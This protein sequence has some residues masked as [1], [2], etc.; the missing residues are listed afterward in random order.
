MHIFAPLL[1]IPLAWNYTYGLITSFTLL[2]LSTIA[3]MITVYSYEFPPTLAYMG[4]L[5]QAYNAE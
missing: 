2:V 4:K 3:N 5:P 1:L